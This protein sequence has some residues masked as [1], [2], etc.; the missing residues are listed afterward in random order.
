MEPDQPVEKLPNL[1]YAQWKYQLLL[2]DEICPEKAEIKK[3]LMEAISEHNMAPF[4]LNLCEE[5]KWTVDQT[6]L[7]KMNEEN[8]KK[9]EKLEASI[10]DALENLGE[11]EVKDAMLA[12]ADHFNR[13]GDKAKAI[14]QYQLTFEQTVGSGQKLDVIF[15]NIRMGLF[16]RDNDLTKK[17]IDKA[18][19]MVDAGSDWDRRNRLKVYEGVY[20]MSIRN[21][22]KAA[23][24][25]LETLS[26]FSAVELMDYKTFIYYT[27]LMSAV[28]LDRPHLKKKII[29][30]P[31]VLA[32][33]DSLP[34]VGEFMQSLYQLNY[35]PFI[36]ALAQITDLIKKDYFLAAHAGFFCKEMRI[37]AYSQLLESYRSVTLEKIAQSFGVSV[38][39]I[40]SELS[41]FIASGRL[42]AKI[43]KVGGVVDTN[44]SDSKSIQFHSTVKSGDLLLNRI[45]KLSRASA[46]SKRTHQRF[47][48]QSLRVVF[49]LFRKT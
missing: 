15:T 24:L 3:K 1:D 26:T 29:D 30:S 28:S 12:K 48:Q 31:E 49:K 39:F 27:I 2:P 9:L 17:N 10:K 14:P 33:V 19:S 44:R 11:S 40:D 43:D 13:I 18:R 6:L 25:F 46:R 21:F 35:A 36:Q 7:K 5:L 42:N 34:F 22:H 41:R 38:E 16:W 47:L 23:H 4:Y 37:I 20:N 45:Q 8:E 32:V